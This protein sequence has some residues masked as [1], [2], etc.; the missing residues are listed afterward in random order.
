MHY[1][2]W[3]IMQWVE[4]REKHPP[5]TAE[6]RE[7]LR[8]LAKWV[9]ENVQQYHENIASI[10]RE[11]RHYRKI[12]QRKGELKCSYKNGLPHHT[13]DDND[14]TN[15][16]D[17]ESRQKNEERAKRCKTIEGMLIIILCM[18]VRMYVCMYVCTYVCIDSMD[19]E[20][21]RKRSA[22]GQDDT[23]RRRGEVQRLIAGQ[24]SFALHSYAVFST[25]EE[26]KKKVEKRKE[27]EREKPGQL[28][29]YM[30][31]KELQ[32]EGSEPVDSLLTALLFEDPKLP[33]VILS[34]PPRRVNITSR[35]KEANFLDE[36]GMSLSIP[37]NATTKD[38]QLDLATS[39]SGAYETP[40]DIC[41][42]SPAYVIKSTESIEFSKEVVVKL[43]HTANI[44]TEEDY[45]DIVV[46]KASSSP[47][48]RSSTS[49]RSSSNGGGITHKFEEVRG[50]KVEFGPGY[51]V[52]KMKSFFS[53]IFKVGKR[54]LQR[55]SKQVFIAELR[56][57]SVE[58]A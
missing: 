58:H 41:P 50:T 47:K 16:T 33:G 14:G 1:Y 56:P 18:Y 46:M 10:D 27:S 28:H 21:P 57:N 19:Q 35:G 24:Y 39:F 4:D 26:L 51:V 22:D 20:V 43:Q 6:D 40:S 23:Q 31:L 15:V 25:S 9:E 52:M 3:A 30:Q 45:K 13:R 5:T 53:S 42:V 29:S 17:L 11:I 37:K 48:K 55:K 44:V 7:R 2:D 54:M 49:S 12:L 36:M 8:E 38:E 34:E 32:F